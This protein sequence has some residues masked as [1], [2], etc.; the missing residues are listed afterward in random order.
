MLKRLLARLSRIFNKNPANLAAI[1]IEGTQQTLTICDLVATLLTPDGT[2]NQAIPIDGLSGP[3]MTINDLVA[4]FNTAGFTTSLLSSGLGTYPARG[5]F[6]TTEAVGSTPA[7]LYYPTS[8]FYKEM[9]TYG[10]VLQDQANRITAAAAMLNMRDATDIWLDYWGSLFDVFR[11]PGESDVLYGPR[12][13]WQ[14]IQPNQNN[15]AL[16]I[17]VMNTLGLDVVIQDAVDVLSS[18][19]IGLQSNA[20][21][22]FLLDWTP[23]SSLTTDEIAATTAQIKALVRQYK[24]AGFDFLEQTS[25]TTVTESDSLTTSENVD[26]MLAVQLSESPQP[27]TLIAGTGWMAGTPGL[28]AGPNAAILEQVYVQL[29]LDLDGSTKTAVLAGG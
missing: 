5:L 10:W 6:E 22:R 12:I 20:P 26:L 14:I 13:F 28:V 11:N 18:I 9:Q 17:I 16:E 1:S 25:G 3:V 7:I 23:D 19:D 29:I 4:A 8:I 15:V 21:G 2:V 27:G 24:A